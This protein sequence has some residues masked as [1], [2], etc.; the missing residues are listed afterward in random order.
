MATK[1]TKRTTVKRT[2]TIRVCGFTS[3]D[4]NTVH[5]LT[6]NHWFG[7]IGSIIRVDVT[8]NN[9]VRVAEIRFSSQKEAQAALRWVHQYNASKPHHKLQANYTQITAHTKPSSPQQHQS[10]QRQLRTLSSDHTKLKQ[11]NQLLHQIIERLQTNL[12][13]NEQ[14]QVN[15]IAQNKKLQNESQNTKNSQLEQKELY[16]DNQYLRRQQQTLETEANRM[17]KKIKSI[18]AENKRLKQITAILETDKNISANQKHKMQMNY[19]VIQQQFNVMLHQRQRMLSERE[20]SFKKWHLYK[21]QYY[22]VTEWYESL[23]REY[24]RVLN[25]R[26]VLVQPQPIVS[27]SPPSLPQE[28]VE[29]TIQCMADNFDWLTVCHWIVGI[30]GGI[31]MKYVNQLTIALRDKKIGFSDLYKM[32]ENDL[33]EIGVTEW[34]DVMLLFSEIQKLRLSKQCANISMI[35]NVNETAMRSRYQR[36]I[37]DGSNVQM[38][39]EGDPSPLLNVFVF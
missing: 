22:V 35:A 24:L 38:E 2:N 14:K 12:H 1:N 10:L 30:Q 17:S 13:R 26:R 20:H 29:Q 9:H 32:N 19:A 16:D 8:T 6:S 5:Q 11:K 18:E 39:I 31:F 25:E 4:G 15:L 3:F 34:K 27:P 36:D 28:P 37:N 7:K 23:K 21:E 33:R